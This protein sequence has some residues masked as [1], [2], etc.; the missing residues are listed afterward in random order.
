VVPRETALGVV[1]EVAAAG[2]SANAATKTDT[3]RETVRFLMMGG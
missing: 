1:W 3:T 2:I